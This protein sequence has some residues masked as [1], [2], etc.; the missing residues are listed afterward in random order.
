MKFGY[1]PWTSSAARDRARWEEV[2]GSTLQTASHERAVT[3]VLMRVRANPSADMLKGTSGVAMPRDLF[4]LADEVAQSV[5]SVA[6]TPQ[7]LAGTM[8]RS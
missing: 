3:G 1:A 7:R 5:P 6:F 2:R 8:K 4:D